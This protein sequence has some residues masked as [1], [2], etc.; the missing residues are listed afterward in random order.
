MTFPTM[1]ASDWYTG[2]FAQHLIKLL[3]FTDQLS[4]TEHVFLLISVAVH[5]VECS[6]QHKLIFCLYLLLVLSAG[7]LFLVC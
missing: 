6:F 4:G 1:H 7:G 3:Y 5:K 2:S